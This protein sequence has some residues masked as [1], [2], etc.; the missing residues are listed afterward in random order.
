MVRN[1]HN[2]KSQHE[3]R[4]SGRETRDLGVCHLVECGFSLQAVSQLI[5]LGV[6]RIKQILSDRVP[7]FRP[8]TLH[9]ESGYTF[10]EAETVLSALV[11]AW[12]L[13]HSAIVPNARARL[14][15]ARL[16]HTEEGER[17][18][19]AMEAAGLLPRP[20]DRESIVRG[21][22]AWTVQPKQRKQR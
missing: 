10:V 4:P 20:E 16:V 13:I 7:H 11:D 14:G 6:P 12:P 17:L 15:G 18:I 9:P 21:Y 1:S 8:D 22:T 2:L 19:S 5:G 3:E